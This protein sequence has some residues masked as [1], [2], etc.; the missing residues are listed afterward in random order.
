VIVSIYTVIKWLTAPGAVFKALLEHVICRI[1]R[2]PITDAR[3]LQKNEL[4][5]HVEHELICGTAKNF[6]F[7]FLPVFIQLILGTAVSAS[8]AIELFYY[9]NWPSFLG[10]TEVSTLRG[11]SCVIGLWV[12]VSLLTNMFPLLEDAAAFWDSIYGREKK[13][14][15]AVIKKI[16]LLPFACIAMVGAQMEAFGLTLITSAAYVFAIPLVLSMFL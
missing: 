14:T 5:G 10:A 4:C 11:V 13:G 15:G 9:G 8:C 1:Y 6:F 16:L 3:Y 7:I 2:I 12:G